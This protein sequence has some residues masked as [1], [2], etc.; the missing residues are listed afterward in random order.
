MT[1]YIWSILQLN[2]YPKID[3]KTDVVV[4]AKWLLTGVGKGATATSGGLMQFPLP[5]GDNF[6]PYE[7]LT[8]AQV[9]GWVQDELGIVGIEETK[10]I[11]EQQI[12]SIIATPYPPIPQPLPWS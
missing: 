4:I 2:C 9:I 10:V 8:E 5:V 1:E 12:N 7:D 3:N 11:I 6:T